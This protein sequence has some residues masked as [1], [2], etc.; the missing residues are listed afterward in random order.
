MPWPEPLALAGVC[1][2]GV[3]SWRQASRQKVIYWCI[4]A[5]AIYR[6]YLER[7]THKKLAGYCLGNLFVKVSS[8]EG[9]LKENQGKASYRKL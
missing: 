8:T 2:P 1:F 9:F 3:L 4:I 7:K 6:F 5:H